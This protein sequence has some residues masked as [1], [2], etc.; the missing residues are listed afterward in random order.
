MLGAMKS[1]QR[2]REFWERAVEQAESSGKTRAQCAK[3]LGVGGP[4]L[5]YWIYKLRSERRSSSGT[6]PCR[7]LVPVRVVESGPERS[8]GLVL[9]VDGMTVRFDEQTSVEYVARLAGALRQC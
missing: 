4:A 9:E 6:T 1:K 8:N 2:R 7:A 5:S 3:E